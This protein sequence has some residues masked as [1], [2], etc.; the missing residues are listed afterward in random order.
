MLSSLDVAVI[1]RPSGRLYTTVFCK[2]CDTGNIL[3]CNSHHL[4]E[5]KRCVVLTFIVRANT[6]PSTDILRENEYERLLLSF[7]GLNYPERLCYEKPI[8]SCAEERQSPV[9]SV[10][11]ARV[12]IPYVHGVSE[13]ITTILMQVDIQMVFK[14]Y[15]TL[16]ALVSNPK[17][18]T[19]SAVR[20]VLGDPTLVR[21]RSDTHWVTSAR[22]HTICM[23]CCSLG[24]E[25]I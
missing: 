11:R 13:T 17:T 19:E 9:Y 25:L 6:L 15:R 4:A 22:G 8:Q 18:S 20:V 14:P 21:E 12:C 24:K 5:H 1:R 23:Q 16:R 7:R 2:E 3:N 10:S